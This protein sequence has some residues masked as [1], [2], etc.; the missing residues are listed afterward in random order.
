MTWRQFAEEFCF[1]RGMFEDQ[2]KA[3]VDTVIESDKNGAMAHRWS[4]DIEG[5]PPQMKAVIA[6]S[7]K[8]HALRWI[9]EHCPQAWF[10]PVFAE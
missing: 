10:R 9:D 1:E 8:A 7:V 2:A 5:Y 3:V 6:A 4:D